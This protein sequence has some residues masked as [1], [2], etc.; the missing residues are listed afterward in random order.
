MTWWIR[1][2]YEDE[3]LWSY[4][5]ADDEGWAARHVEIR[6]ADGAPTAACLREVLHLRDHGDLGAMACYERR[7]GVLAEGSLEGWRDHAGAVEMS[8]DEFE[9]LWAK[10]RRA[11]GRSAGTACGPGCPGHTPGIASAQFESTP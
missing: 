8:G 9:R 2:L 3:G 4:F 10:A 1:A 6:A 5:E 7:Y 11:L